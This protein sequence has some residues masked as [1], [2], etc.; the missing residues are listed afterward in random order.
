[1]S[2]DAA[3]LPASHVEEL[4]RALLRAL[5]AFQMYL[6]N[7][8]M[9]HRGAQNLQEAFLPVWAVLG[10]LTFTVTETELIWEGEAVYSQ[11]NKSESFAFWLHK[12][13]MRSFT[14]RKGC[15]EDEAARLLQTIS[16][17][18]A[19]WLQVPRRLARAVAFATRWP[20]ARPNCGLLQ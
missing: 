19:S 18:F 7:N 14:L 6:P 20:A 16:L 15:E 2:L 17:A 12:D 4:V 8:P 9:Y 1:M 13:G 5:R 10:E 11:P 3:I